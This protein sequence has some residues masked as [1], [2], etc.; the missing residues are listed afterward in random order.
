MA[1]SDNCP[2]LM[3]TENVLLHK[4]AASFCA[5]SFTDNCPKLGDTNNVLLSKIAASLCALMGGSGAFIN[6]LNGSGTGITFFGATVF[7][8]CIGSSLI[9]CPDNTHDVGGVGGKPRDIL[10]GRNIDATSAYTYQGQEVIIANLSLNNVFLAGA[11]NLTMT[12]SFNMAT[13]L[14]SLGNNTTGIRNVA[15]GYQTLPANTTG[16]QNTAVGYQALQF[17]LSGG[18][19]VA[20][21]YEVLA[22]N[23]AGENSVA[24]GYQSTINNTT[25]GFGVAIGNSTLADQT[26]GFLNTAIGYNTG[27]GITTGGFNTI[28]GAQVTGLAAGLTNNIII[29]DGSGNQRITADAAG[30]VTVAQS[31]T[32]GKNL[33]V[34]TGA[35]TRA[36]NAVLAAGTRTIANTTVTANTLLFHS[37]KI[38]GGTLGNLTYTITPGI[39]FTIN[40]D[41]G[42]DTSTVSYLLVENP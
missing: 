5:M 22:S 42:G 29:A 36:G 9:F 33:V 31:L 38:A 3:D 17:N 4:I 14:S 16:N 34:P 30:D 6:A 18:R 2:K 15:Y 27:R 25:G 32:I 10:A 37:R 21:G 26:E 24:I 40:S 12:G 28:I 41:N 23:T 19:N 8:G 11:G 39:A 1:Y 7:N 13:G 35:N 20:V